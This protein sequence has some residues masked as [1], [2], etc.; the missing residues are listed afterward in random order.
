[1]KKYVE[2]MK[3]C[4]GNNSEI[5]RTSLIVAL[6]VGKIPRALSLCRGSGFD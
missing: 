5:P 6:G 4:E 2:N 3:K 1:M